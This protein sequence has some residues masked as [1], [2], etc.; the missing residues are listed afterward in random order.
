MMITVHEQ[1][2]GVDPNES[3]LLCHPVKASTP[4]S[5]QLAAFKPSGGQAA[6]SQQV[7]PPGGQESG[8][9]KE[10]S[11]KNDNAKCGL[12]GGKSGNGQSP[13]VSKSAV[14]EQASD[15][16]GGPN[17]PIELSSD[18]SGSDG[19]NT[20]SLLKTSS[21][22]S[23]GIR[24]TDSCPSVMS[25]SGESL[26]VVQVDETGA[27]IVVTQKTDNVLSKSLLDDLAIGPPP[28]GPPTMGPPPNP[29]EEAELERKKQKVTAE[30]KN[31]KTA[32]TKAV[33]KA[34]KCVEL[35]GKSR[36]RGD[37]EKA[38]EAEEAAAE[39]HERVKKAELEYRQIV[40]KVRKDSVKGVK[41]DLDPNSPEKEEPR[42]KQ[43]STSRSERKREASASRE[44]K[45]NEST[46]EETKS[47]E[48]PKPRRSPKSSKLK[49]QSPKD[50]E[51]SKG[52]AASIFK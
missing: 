5:T 43:R 42:A 15:V 46:S 36:T 35:A 52:I 6:P 9:R 7:A 26:S 8:E 4:N 27:S 17:N 24:S 10:V 13:S 12:E 51:L 23:S 47:K 11:P 33:N 29:D 40:G 20:D 49:Q 19:A 45:K 37:L 16:T 25:T 22:S 30:L 39:A 18:T 14:S 50:K 28:L 32:H 44:R 1:V 38:E 2:V 3:R 48:E 21:S 34:R 41:R 31:A